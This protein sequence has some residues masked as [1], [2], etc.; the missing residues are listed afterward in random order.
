MMT[1]VPT[2]DVEGVHGA[3]PFPEFVRG[4]LLHHDGEDWGV[5]RQA[6]IFQKHGV[7]ATFFVDCYEYTLWGEKQL[8]DVC[9]R[10]VQM[11]QDVQLHTHPAWRDDI[12]DYGWLRA[13]KAKKSFFP[14]YLDL[15]A[16]LSYA[17]QV[18]VLDHGISL[19]QKWTGKRPTVHRSGGYSIDENTIRALRDV[20]IPM[21]S[22]MH[23]A[24]SNSKVTWATNRLVHRHGL[25]E[26]P[27]TVLRNSIELPLRSE[28]PGR[29]YGKLFNT[30]MD[31]CRL[32][33]FLGYV[34]QGIPLNVKV[35]NL[36]MHSYSL[37]QFD[38]YYKTIRPSPRQAEKLDD[39]LDALGKRKDV[40]L[41]SCDELLGAF[42]HDP[43]SFTSDEA[44]PTLPATRKI[45]RLAMAKMKNI[46]VDSGVRALDR[47]RYRQ[48]S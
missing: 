33:D 4:E 20:G 37:L 39:L 10:L 18:E 35:M 31:C 19:L 43:E 24:H 41:M 8:E 25:L 23:V 48:A 13:L 6:A 3:R 9:C 2:I 11:G 47:A 22:S 36:F 38:P 1:V 26:L 16:K 7:S 34:D 15:M 45:V 5:F 40:Q 29:F 17:Q 46:L 32:E 28:S 12:H 14:Q 27:I 21:D 44:I 42:Q 30:D